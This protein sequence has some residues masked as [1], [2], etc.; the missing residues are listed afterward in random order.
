MYPMWSNSHNTM[1]SCVF[2]F[3]LSYQL[4]A[5]LTSVWLVLYHPVESGHNM[6]KK[7]RISSENSSESGQK[8]WPEFFGRNYRRN[9]VGLSCKESFEN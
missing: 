1:V 3:S 6:V 4:L 2:S 7:G 8:G 5:Q 9:S